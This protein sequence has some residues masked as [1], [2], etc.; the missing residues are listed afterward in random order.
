MPVFPV[1]RAADTDNADYYVNYVRTGEVLHT[2]LVLARECHDVRVM[3]DDWSS[4]YSAI[5]WNPETSAPFSVYLFT[6]GYGAQN[7]AE[8]DATPEVVAAYAAW[9]DAQA[10]KAAA[11]DHLRRC[12]DARRRLFLP[13]LGCPARVVRGR[14][15]PVGTEGLVTW[16]GASTYGARVG[17]TDSSGTLHYTAE[18]NVERTGVELLDGEDWLDVERRLSPAI[19][20]KW[21]K[22]RIKQGPNAGTTGTIMFIRDERVGIATSNRKQGGRYV[23][24]VWSFTAAVEVIEA[25]EGQEPPSVDVTPPAPKVVAPF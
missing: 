18:S 13:K 21:D 20:Y 5:V 9:K 22:V 4:A 14:K 10:A 6:V 19:P 23:D 8:I 2:G 16:S 15:I 17:I 3:S 11:A 24:V 1:T 7:E 12:E 25:R